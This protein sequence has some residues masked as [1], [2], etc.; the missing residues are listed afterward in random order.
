MAGGKRSAAGRKTAGVRGK[1]ITGKQKSARRKN[2]AIARKFKKKQRSKK[3]Y[4]GSGKKITA[5]ERKDLTK[6][7]TKELDRVSRKR[8]VKSLSKVSPKFSRLASLI[9]SERW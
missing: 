4:F 6:R 9:A 8:K 7:A 2:I 1:R 3:Q 5:K